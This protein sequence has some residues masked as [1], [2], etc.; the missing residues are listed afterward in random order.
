MDK[1]PECQV[2]FRPRCDMTTE[3]IRDRLLQAFPQSKVQVE[4]LTGGNDHY[5]VMVVSD[6]FAGLSRIK[7]HQ[8]VMQVFDA[9][10]KSGEIHAFTIQTRTKQL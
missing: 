6:V 7:A 9:E 8:T 5:A 2:P 1:L 4:D 10:L 3:A